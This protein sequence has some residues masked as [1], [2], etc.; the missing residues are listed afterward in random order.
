[1]N[2]NSA[3]SALS[4][5]AHKDRLA[6]FRLI[7]KHSPKGLPSGEVAHLLAIAPTRMSFHLTTLQKAG[8]LTTH[9][10]GRQVF[11]AL[12]NSTMQ[13]LLHFLT[14][15]CCSAGD[16]TCSTSDCQLEPCAPTTPP[17]I[18]KSSL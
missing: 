5:L 1:M 16:E 8:L 13:S 9:K 6:A 17:D 2:E 15:N 4:A 3:I 11:Y 10:H 14:E 18:L 12:H 7:L